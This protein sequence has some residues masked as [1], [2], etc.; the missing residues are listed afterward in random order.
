MGRKAR[1]VEGEVAHSVLFAFPVSA[2]PRFTY[3]CSGVMPRVLCSACGE[4]LGT[5]RSKLSHERDQCT[6]VWKFTYS[7]TTLGA[8]VYRLRR[9]STTRDYQLPCS[10]SLTFASL[11]EARRHAV[12]CTNPPA[13][14]LLSSYTSQQVYHQVDFHPPPHP[15]TITIID[16]SAAAPPPPPPQLAPPVPQL[17]PPLPHPQPPP[18]PPPPF[19]P[20]PPPPPHSHRPQ[21]M[22]VD[23]EVESEPEREEPQPESE[24]EEMEGDKTTEEVALAGEQGEVDLEMEEIKADAEEEQTRE[25]AELEV[26]E[27]ED[28]ALNLLPALDDDI[29]EVA[30]V[31]GKGLNVGG[32]FFTVNLTGEDLEEEEPVQMDT[33]E[34]GEKVA[35]DPLEALRRLELVDL[36]EDT[37]LTR[38]PALDALGLVVHTTTSLLICLECH[39]AINASS[40]ANHFHNSHAHRIPPTA[41]LNAQAALTEL[42]VPPGIPPNA[43]PYLA[44]RSP[45]AP[46]PP[47]LPLIP[48]IAYTLDGF[49]CSACGLANQSH[50]SARIHQSTVVHPNTT[51]PPAILNVAVQSIYRSRQQTHWVEVEMGA[52]P[53]PDEVKE[54]WARLKGE[55][56]QLLQLLRERGMMTPTRPNLGQWFLRAL[57][58]EVIIIL[59]NTTNNPPPTATP[60]TEALNLIAI[61]SDPN[62]TLSRTRPLARDFVVW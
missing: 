19:P 59:P 13:A 15:P 31:D 28:Q 8:Q 20:P 1:E 24:S 55:G 3:H 4:V 57:R 36:D 62:D 27:E 41:L 5:E 46:R 11:T 2:P 56:A 22:D 39:A 44:R 51:A 35:K 9:H 61:P 52:G 54:Q 47:P 38:R 34:E 32:G 12:S 10:C 17:A 6:G 33:G 58:I 37:S 25:Q 18:Q 53:A 49:S 40:L 45:A 7:N 14:P 23:M 21:P 50:K 26:D 60:P 16:P 29:D 42:Q 30:G 48:S 43:Q